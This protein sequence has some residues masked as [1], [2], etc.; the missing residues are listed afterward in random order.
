M[1]CHDGGISSPQ[2]EPQ[3][4]KDW[5]AHERDLVAH[6][7]R[8]EVSISP[9]TLEGCLV[10]MCDTVAYLSRDLV[11]AVSLGII[12]KQQ[13]PETA[14]GRDN[15][16]IQQRFAESLIDCSRD[17][18]FIAISQEAYDAIKI[19]RQFS[20][21]HI[22]FEPR[23][24]SESDKIKRCYKLLID[25]LLSDAS[26]GTNSYLWKHFLHSKTPAYLESTP[27]ERQVIDY[28]SGMTDGYFL[29]TIQKLFVPSLIGLTC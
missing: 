9:M 21:D 5:Q 28:V 1:L 15:T 10:K 24:K 7:E 11:D 26:Q 17:Q 23:L 6:M 29:R 19:L 14:L 13:I 27:L 25:Y 3:W 12:Q 22:Y 20:F 8:P 4:N 2:L 16:E 18:P